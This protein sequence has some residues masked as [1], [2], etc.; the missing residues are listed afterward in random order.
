MCKYSKIQLIQHAQHQRVARL[1]D[2][3]DYQIVPIQVNL[4]LLLY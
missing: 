1:L 3:L 2:I 4:L